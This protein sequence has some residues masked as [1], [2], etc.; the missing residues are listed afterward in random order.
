MNTRKKNRSIKKIFTVPTHYTYIGSTVP[1]SCVCVQGDVGGPGNDGVNGTDG[2]KGEKGI[3]GRAGP[4]GPPVSH[5]SPLL[6]PVLL[7]RG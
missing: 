4:P 2:D 7:K 3:N 1:S 6:A 5:N